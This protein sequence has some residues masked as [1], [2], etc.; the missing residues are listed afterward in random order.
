M[1]ECRS[2]SP[3]LPLRLHPLES[4]CGAGRAW[5]CP[6]FHTW[7]ATLPTWGH[8]TTCTGRCLLQP[9]LCGSESAGW[10]EWTLKWGPGKVVQRGAARSSFLHLPPQARG[11]GSG[12]GQSNGMRSESG[13]GSGSWAGGAWRAWYF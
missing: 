1:G 9:G 2:S 7:A 5:P 4:S 6:P 3:P 13:G 11:L 10:V 12:K 8:G